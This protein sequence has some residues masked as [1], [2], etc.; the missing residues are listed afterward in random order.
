MTHFGLQAFVEMS[1]GHSREL[2]ERSQVMQ[3]L[4][5]YQTPALI[6]LLKPVYKTRLNYVHA[7]CLLA[8]E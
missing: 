4:S 1:V 5:V 3:R 2:C 8:D 7:E 6:V